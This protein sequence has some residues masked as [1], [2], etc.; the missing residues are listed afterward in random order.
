M[1]L[2]NNARYTAVS[3]G[4]TATFDLAA[5]AAMPF[6]PTISTIVQS[7]GSDEGYAMLGASPAMREWIGDRQFHQLRS[8]EFT[9][10]NKHWENSVAIERTDIDDDRLGLLDSTIGDLA[11]EAA[12]HPDKLLFEI[13]RD[14]DAN[15][16]W[17]GQFFFDTD[18]SF[19]DSGTNSNDLT[20]NVTTP[21]APTE[22]EFIS[23]Y[24]QSYSAM[25]GFTRD[26][27]E[28]WLRPTA[29]MMGGTVLLVPPALYEGAYQAFRSKSLEKSLA[30]P[31]M[32]RIYSS[33]YLSAA[34]GGDDDVFYT[35]YTGG[36]IKP[37]LFQLRE[38]LRREV[39]GINTIRDKEVKF[40]CE[41][42][43]NCGYLA[44]MYAVRTQLT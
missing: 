40:M 41:A 29:N 19:G 28:P 35:L 31:E 32:P 2:I 3:R 20:Y 30:V 8:A 7:T 14:G 13:L 10:K 4:I 23:A 39:E 17:D 5:A 16:C 37:F 36:R 9:L 34:S 15:E 12:C 38:P 6:Y 43:Y 44:W 11:E 18:H 21:S 27:G 22:E 1:S 26:N 25:L 33:P 42:R 24:W